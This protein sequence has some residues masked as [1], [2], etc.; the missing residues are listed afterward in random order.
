MV[1][2]ILSLFGFGAEGILRG[3]L[4]AILQS[5]GA[6]GAGLAALPALLLSPVTVAGSLVGGALWFFGK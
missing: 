6:G 5:A 2:A 3:S 4:A 1:A